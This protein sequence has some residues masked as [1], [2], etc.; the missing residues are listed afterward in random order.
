V[1]EFVAVRLPSELVL[2]PGLKRE[3][4]MFSRIAIPL[5]DKLLTF[6]G[7][8]D[9]DSVTQF[10]GELEWLLERDIVFDPAT[11]PDRLD[12]TDEEYTKFLTLETIAEKEA[13]HRVP[14]AQRG[15][16]QRALDYPA[17][18]R[19]RDEFAR[20]LAEA[21]QAALMVELY[22]VRRECIR[23]R[24]LHRMD[25]Y[26]VLTLSG[27]LSPEASSNKHQII[28]I[29]INSL[30]FPDDSTSWE[31][32]A[33][34]RSDPDSHSKFLALR[35]WMSEV[36]RAELTPAEVEEKLAYLIDQYQRHM[37]L[38]RMK[39]N[40]GTL[41]T[42]VTTS[43]EVIGDLVSFKWGKAAEA[44]FAIKQRQVALLEGE[45]TAPGSEVAYIVKAREAL[46]K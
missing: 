29:V 46:T 14:E 32:I 20:Q 37:K 7:K 4:L 28:R 12:V 45:L 6:T 23:L 34:F 11:I 22:R 21:T 42:I 38:H 17:A 13:R 19:R 40:T 24:M 26:P 5:L 15:L 44:L 39:T 27:I 35:H 31:Q 33:E 9:T 1:R 10:G 36:A 30:P 8:S 25:A 16:E 41:Q 3:A 2:H 18:M 43:A